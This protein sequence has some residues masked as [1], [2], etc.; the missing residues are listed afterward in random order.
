MATSAPANS[1][2]Q[3]SSSSAVRTTPR[4]ESEITIAGVPNH[5]PAGSKASGYGD[6]R[7]RGSE[8]ENLPL[9]VG[10]AVDGR[11]PLQHHRPVRASVRYP[12]YRARGTPSNGRTTFAALA[13]S[14][15]AKRRSPTGPGVERRWASTS[16]SGASPLCHARSR[17][18]DQVGSKTPRRTD[19]G[20]R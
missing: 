16:A 6:H 18:P 20:Y 3:R 14:A 5:S 4:G 12:M 7:V 19:N 1:M 8:A 11:E 13:W 9:D 10:D 15:R 17:R 2:L